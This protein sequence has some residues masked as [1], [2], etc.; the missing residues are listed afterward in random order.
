MQ[1]CTTCN[2]SGHKKSAH[3][4][5]NGRGFTSPIVHI[6]SVERNADAQAFTST[7]PYTRSLGTY[8]KIELD[9]LLRNP[10]FYY[11][12]KNPEVYGLR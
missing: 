11:D 4:I 2:K 8:K 3:V 5:T 1:K 6:P 10:R 9:Q 12:H 7:L